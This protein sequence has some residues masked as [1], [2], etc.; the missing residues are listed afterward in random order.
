M[1]QRGAT[2]IRASYSLVKLRPQFCIPSHGPRPIGSR[3]KKIKRVFTI[4]GHDSHL[5]H[6]SYYQGRLNKLSFLQPIEP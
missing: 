6:R 4:Y 5:V 2:Y 1:K 3:E